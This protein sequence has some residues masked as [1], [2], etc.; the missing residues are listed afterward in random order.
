MRAVLH[1]LVLVV[2]LSSGVASAAAC[3]LSSSAFGIGRL[4]SWEHTAV[5][6]GFSGSP[7]LGRWDAQGAWK[8]NDTGVGENEWRWQLSA[9]LALHERVQLAARVPVVLTV[10][11]VPGQ[12]GTAGGLGDSLLALRLEPVFQGEYEFLPEL[13]VTLGA[14]LPSGRVADANATAALLGTEATGR[15]AWVF[16]AS[17][18]AE[19]ARDK[20]FAQA[21]AG[22][23]M[24]IASVVQGAL[25]Q[26]GPGAQV[27][28]AGGY[29]VYKDLVTSLVA[30][31][32][33]EGPL[34]A[35]PRDELTGL[36]TG[37]AMVQV[38]DSQA[39]DFGVGPSVSYKLDP[40][41]TLQG[42]LDFFIPAGRLGSN[43]QG[44]ITANLGVRFAYF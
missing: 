36:P 34:R 20:W 8:A 44:R 35:E 28:L 23:T 13:A 16:S 41:W 24:P 25:Q 27:T 15:G 37:G 30:H 3:C 12:R 33:Y 42:G 40:K 14:T 17:L 21:G 29:E 9:L 38:A 31:F 7:V 43:R 32:N 22:F 26:F 11:E 4:A 19:L 2:V 6:F 1:T 39:Y 18:T 10:R 5:Q